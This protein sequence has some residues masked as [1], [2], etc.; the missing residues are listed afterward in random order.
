MRNIPIP[1]DA[2]RLTFVCVTAPRPRLVNKDTGEIKTDKN[3]R[4]VYQV[5]LS[6][7]AQDGRVELINISTSGEP[8]I[9]VGQVAEVAGLVGFAWEQVRN[10]ETRW[11]IAYR[12]ETITPASAGRVQA[13][14]VAA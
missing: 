7:A 2:S 13:E 1:V 9:G 8:S 11:G 4:T 10:G 12:A 5:G 6:A 3:G 14:E